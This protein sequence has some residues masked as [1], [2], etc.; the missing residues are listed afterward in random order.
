MGKA[1]N[2]NKS[3]AFA[4]YMKKKGITRTTGQ[5]PWGCGAKIK[6][7]GPPLLN[8]LRVCQGGGKRRFRGVKV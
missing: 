6:N 1:E 3:Q 7:G 5:C 8:H 4:E 2:R